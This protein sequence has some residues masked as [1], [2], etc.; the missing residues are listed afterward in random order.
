MNFKTEKRKI[1]VAYVL[2]P[3]DFGG[4]EKVSLNFL[5]NFNQS[6]ITSILCDLSRL[7]LLAWIM[8]CRSLIPL[9]C[10]SKAI[11]LLLLN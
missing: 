7:Y 11:L 1:K 3:I 2:T 8:N 9:D 10:N 6:L 4:A 5:K